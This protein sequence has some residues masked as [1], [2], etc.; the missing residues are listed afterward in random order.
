MNDSENR[1]LQMFTRVSDFGTAH[2][3]DF[4]PTSLATQ[5]FTSLKNVVA[6][7]GQEG[8]S[9]SSGLGS[10]RQG[11]TTRGEAREALR[12]DLEAINRTARAMNEEVSGLADKFRV[13]ARGND[14]LLIIA[15]RAA[16]ADAAPLS[17][18]FIAHELSPNFLTHL[19]D[20]IA[21]METAMSSQSGGVGN[22]V[23]ARASIEAAVDEGVTI[24]HR[25]DAIIR[26][27]YAD[28][29][30]TLAEWSSASHTE[31]APRH[32]GNKPPPPT[33]PG[34]GGPSPPA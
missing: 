5:L 12:H 17:A 14:Q 32:R 16:A 7:L 21:A 23:A 27:K 6:R 20:D 22:A 30:G 25:L 4:A 1:R 9:Q 10:A 34:A 2:A 8:A 11:T 26:N 13:P 33:S 19:N 31:R 28:N 3:T 24:T 29:P 15:A 18:Q